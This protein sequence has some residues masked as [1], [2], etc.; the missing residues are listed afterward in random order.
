MTVA[1]IITLSYKKRNF[2][3]L[4]RFT[5]ICL[6][7]LCVLMVSAC[8]TNTKKQP[9]APTLEDSVE[10]EKLKAANLKQANEAPEN[11]LLR[12]AISRGD[13]EML[14]EAI[15]QGASP[16]ARLCIF[17]NKMGTVWIEW[18]CQEGETGG[19][20]LL[21]KIES[22]SYEKQAALIN[23]FA[24]YRPAWGDN[25]NATYGHL[26][27]GTVS[28]ENSRNS[29]VQVTQE[30]ILVAKALFHAGVKLT[31]EYIRDEASYAQ[32][33]SFGD[34]LAILQA[35]AKEAGMLPAFNEGV[36][37]AIKSQNIAE[38]QRQEKI[39]KENQ[40]NAKLVKAIGQKICRSF[41]GTYSTFY[42]MRTMT[43]VVDLETKHQTKVNV[44][45]FTENSN[46]SKIQIR[47]AGIYRMEGNRLINSDKFDGATVYQTNAIVW[48]E[49][50]DWRPCS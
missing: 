20:P 49:S 22:Q 28:T 47:I 25:P 36:S 43:G 10:Q 29:K 26:L 19:D 8:A 24:K 2:M 1:A 48:E 37:K 34:N 18:I 31:S 50:S 4:R 44:T 33:K 35:L 5:S 46:G 14:N 6:T 21:F 7:L 16:N 11:R 17:V 23:A 39:L 12:K 41:D 40:L 9:A 27:S 32:K 30:K 42:P 38:A 13:V 45:A 15:N 3:N